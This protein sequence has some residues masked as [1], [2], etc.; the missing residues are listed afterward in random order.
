MTMLIDG[1]TGVE[2]CL[3]VAAVYNDVKQLWAG[4]QAGYTPTL[5]V[6]YGGLSGELYWY[7]HTNVWENPNA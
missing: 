1:H 2:H 4:T 3:P 6:A 5:G 7:H